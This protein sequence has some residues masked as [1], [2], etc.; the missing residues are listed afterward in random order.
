MASPT[1]KV[2]P[3]A[4]ESEEESIDF[5]PFEVKIDNDKNDNDLKFCLNKL[6]SYL[7][8]ASIIFNS[9]INKSRIFL[10]LP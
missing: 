7:A 6:E 9:Q 1:D 2:V 4:H 3:D 10:I 5:E 8:N